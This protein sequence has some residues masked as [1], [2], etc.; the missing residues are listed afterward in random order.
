MY[1]DCCEYLKG[2]RVKVLYVEF[3]EYYAR[4]F[5]IISIQWNL[6]SC[7]LRVKLGKVP[8][9]RFYKYVNT[10]KSLKKNRKL[11]DFRK[12]RHDSCNSAFRWLLGRCFLSAI[13]DSEDGGSILFWNDPEL[14][15][16]YTASHTFH[17][18]PC[19]NV[20]TSSLFGLN[21]L[22]IH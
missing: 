19:E 3:N 4:K 12:Y 22:L 13:F 6:I 7:T 20:T 10:L 1:T 17:N 15:S 16:G 11:H 8:L 9:A 14:L 18:H 5:P 21:N 2:W